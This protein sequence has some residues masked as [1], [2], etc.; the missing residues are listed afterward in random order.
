MFDWLVGHFEQLL[1]SGVSARLAFFSRVCLCVK[2][3]ARWR[4]AKSASSHLQRFKAIKSKRERE[5]KKKEEESE[6]KIIFREKAI[7]IY[8]SLTIIIIFFL[9]DVAI[10][11]NPK[12]PMRSCSAARF[13]NLLSSSNNNNSSKRRREGGRGGKKKN[14]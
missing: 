2:E 13:C 5:K 10:M 12:M 9:Y 6:G 4:S 14:V 1:P 11:L 7:K 3:H 8:V